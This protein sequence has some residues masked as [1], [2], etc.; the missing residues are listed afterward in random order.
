MRRKRN[1]RIN[2]H[3]EF[4][5]IVFTKRLSHKSTLETEVTTFVEFKSTSVD[6]LD[7]SSI[8]PGFHIK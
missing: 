1:F 2:D 8:R 7:E 3:L 4:F 6:G 5:I